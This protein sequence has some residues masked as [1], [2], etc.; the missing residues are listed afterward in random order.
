MLESDGSIA[1]LAIEMR[2]FLLGFPSPTQTVLLLAPALFGLG[3][4]TH[5]K[6]LGTK[7][8]KRLN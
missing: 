6:L 1:M 3:E 7:M 5:S 4:A 8:V 2:V